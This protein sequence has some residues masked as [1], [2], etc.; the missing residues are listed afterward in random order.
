MNNN[1]FC[2]EKKEKRPLKLGRTDKTKSQCYLKN[3][4]K[5]VHGQTYNASHKKKCSLGLPNLIAIKG[6]FAFE[7][8]IN[9]V[10]LLYCQSVPMH[11]KKRSYFFFSM[12]NEFVC[13]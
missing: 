3:N 11:G 9:S 1:A 13:R 6:F 2:L 8:P 5:N 12:N 7:N 4:H 10:M